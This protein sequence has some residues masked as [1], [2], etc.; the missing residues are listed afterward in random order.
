MAAAPRER[1]GAA[2]TGYAKGANQP[3]VAARK[4]TATEPTEI[5]PAAS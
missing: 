2:F 5:E 1:F 3:I 4:I